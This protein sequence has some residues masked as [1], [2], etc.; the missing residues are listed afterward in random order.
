MF[1]VK[2]LNH[3]QTEKRRVK[4][5]LELF[6][7]VT[8]CKTSEFIVLQEAKQRSHGSMHVYC[9][10][11]PTCHPRSSREQYVLAVSSTDHERSTSSCKNM[12]I[13]PPRSLTASDA[14]PGC[15]VQ[16][17]ISKCK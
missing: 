13:S 1:I 6:V 4:F 14:L 3:R 7:S 15:S 12:M 5:R 11:R 2:T 17:Y 9:C 16:E 10:A 8:I